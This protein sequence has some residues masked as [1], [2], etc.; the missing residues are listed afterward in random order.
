MTK[1]TQA[2]ALSTLTVITLLI[3]IFVRIYYF[4]VLSIRWP[5]ILL[6]GVLLVGELHM[7]LH[8]LGFAINSVRLLRD[9]SR[10]VIK[11][12]T[13][14]NVPAVDI[15][16]PTRNEPRFVIEQTLITLL[17]I[18]YA[19][20]QVCLIDGSDNEKTINANRYLC[21]KYGAKY[22]KQPRDVGAKAG[23]IN[24]YAQTA[25]AKYFLVLDADQNPMPDILKKL[26]GIAEADP[27]IAFVQ[28]PQYYSNTDVSPIA[29]AAAMQQS[30]FFEVVCEAKNLVNAAF[31]CGTN[32]LINRRL[33]L[34]VGGFDEKS[35]TEDFATSLEWHSL[36]YRSVYYNNV[37]VF[38]MAPESLPAYLK[39][40]HRWA[41]GTFGVLRRVVKKFFQKPTSLTLGQW[42][43]YFLSSSY[44]FVGWSFFFLMMCP[45]IF[46]LFD[47]PIYFMSFKVYAVAFFPYY[48]LSMVVFFS[49]MKKRHYGA[50]QLFNGMIMN[51]LNFPVL[52]KAT[53][54]GLLNIK[55]KFVVTTKGKADK[56]P[57]FQMWPWLGMILLN[58]IA[59]G[60]GMTKFSGNSYSIG[61]NM[62]WC[63]Y[64]CFIL[65]YAVKLNKVPK[66]P[67]PAAYKNLP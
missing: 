31:C 63:V 49:T 40:Q 67:A 6:A 15:L 3:Y 16:V 62:F 18:D 58:I 65:S 29:L 11:K 64:H 23:G 4:F 37:K 51:S 17:N 10:L 22:F 38:G 48:I 66:L 45:I 35:V 19:N 42:W 56:M 9:K 32:V 61:V 27:K 54:S 13:G 24:D 60:V 25:D 43:E 20:K 8:T 46:L 36:G 47:Q 2:I 26:V 57:W 39:Q 7:L 12:M 30:V 50:K 44:Y 52:M 28:T 5:D 59:F 55:T 1:K 34:A 53:L 14:K 33:L 21:K 41:A